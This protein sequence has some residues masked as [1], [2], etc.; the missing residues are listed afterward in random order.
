MREHPVKGFEIAKSIEM[1]KPIMSAVRN[2]HERWDG[3]GYPLA[4]AGEDI[5]IEG[6]ITAVADVFDALPLIAGAPASGH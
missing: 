1:L 2:H 6:R 4:L 3:S 5:P